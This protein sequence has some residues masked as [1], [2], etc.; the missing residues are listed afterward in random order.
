MYSL[1]AGVCTGPSLVQDR[2]VLC[3]GWFSH[4]KAQG[5]GCAMIFNRGGA[6]N[7]TFI[8]Q[9]N[10]LVLILKVFS[11]VKV[12]KNH[13]LKSLPIK[14]KSHILWAFLWEPS[15]TVSHAVEEKRGYTRPR[16]EWKET[17]LCTG[18]EWTVYFCSSVKQTEWCLFS[19][20]SN[21][22]RHVTIRRIISHQYFKLINSTALHQDL[23]YLEQVVSQYF[24]VIAKITKT[25][26]VYDLD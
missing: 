18:R 2:P 11:H 25:C 4:R 15:G 8:C 9:T 14:H 20:L 13:C 21:W 26:S 22:L 5:S 16:F 19:S 12:K 17:S 23:Q 7:Q 1:Q 10:C 24:Q 6:V 3:V